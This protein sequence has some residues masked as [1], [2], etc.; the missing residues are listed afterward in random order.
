MSFR[1]FCFLFYLVLSSC[2]YFTNFI[3]GFFFI[4]FIYN[5]EYR[6]FLFLFIFLFYF[7]LKKKIGLKTTHIDVLRALYF[8]LGWSHDRALKPSGQAKPKKI[9]D[10]HLIYSWPHGSFNFQGW[11][12]EWRYL[13][14]DT[15][16]F[17][18][19]GPSQSSELQL[20]NYRYR[21][22]RRNKKE[23]NQRR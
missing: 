5:F 19:F 10:G 23:L 17:F 11:F 8:G 18:F 1:Y 14:F 3:H 6:K 20:K 13:M 21:G 9:V 2:S 12:Y 7:Y 15:L 16:S 22:T 4:F